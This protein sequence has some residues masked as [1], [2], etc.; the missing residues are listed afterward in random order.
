MV[1]G[2]GAIRDRAH[3]AW[4]GWAERAGGGPFTSGEVEGA[5]ILRHMKELWEGHALEPIE[6]FMH[7]GMKGRGGGGRG[8]LFG[9]AL[10]GV[11]RVWACIGWATPPIPPN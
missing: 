11:G 9:H 10:E 6:L 2:Y 4:V 5:K 1:E 7:L 3:E 8:A